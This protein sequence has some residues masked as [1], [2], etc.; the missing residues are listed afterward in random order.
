MCFYCC[1]VDELICVVSLLLC[2]KVSDA[3]HQHLRDVCLNKAAQTSNVC[4]HS[5]KSSHDA[6]LDSA[7]PGVSRWCPRSTRL[8]TGWLCAW[9]VQSVLS[10]LPL[11]VRGLTPPPTLISY[12]RNSIIKEKVLIS[13]N[14]SRFGAAVVQR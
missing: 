11:S 7:V 13:L 6:F 5:G 1:L 3:P 4:F 8:L 2:I 14:I 10:W 9:G 12:Q